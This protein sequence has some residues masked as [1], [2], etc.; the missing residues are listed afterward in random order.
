M[1]TDNNLSSRVSYVKKELKSA[2]T[3]LFFSIAILLLLS[4]WNSHNTIKVHQDYQSSLM[5][6][7]TQQVINEYQN[8]LIQ[9]RQEIDKFQWRNQ[10]ELMDL[11]RQGDLTER[12]DYLSLLKTFR[13][14]LDNV[15][16]FSII[17][18]Q[19][20]GVFKN[21][22]GDFLADCK[23]EI[24]ST[25]QNDGQEQLFL[26][27]S[28]SSVHYDL[29]QPLMGAQD[30]L[31]IFVA[32][33]PTVFKEILEKY[34]LP[35]Q[36]LFLLRQDRKVEIELNERGSSQFSDEQLSETQ[37]TEFSYLKEIPK[38][39][40]NVA[41]RL[42][43][44]YASNLVWNNYLWSLLIWFTFSTLLLFSYFSQKQKSFGQLKA[45][46]QLE[47]SKSHD[48]LTGLMTRQV[49]VDYFERVKSSIKSEQG[50]AFV[51]DLDKFQLFNNSVGFTK[52][53][54][55]LR[56]IADFIKNIIPDEAKFS[57][58][59]NDQFAILY[60][61]LAHRDALDYANVLRSSVETLDI[62]DIAKNFSLTSCIAVVQL[63]D[64]IAD[65]EHLMS[66][67]L[68][69]IKSAK[70]K[71]RN[72][73]L[74]YQSDDP[75]LVQHASEM[76]IYRQVQKALKG[77]GFEL[78]RQEIR[79]NKDTVSNKVYEVLIRLKG[80]DG[81]IISPAIFI[82]IAEQ[83]SIANELD[84][85]VIEKTLIN[86]AVSQS[87]D[88]YCINLSGQTLADVGMIDFVK[89]KV[90]QYGV[91]PELVT[92]EITET[93]AITHLESA[94]GFINEITQLGCR[95]A[96]DDFGSGLSSFSYLQKLPVQKLKI[97]GVFIK[98]I[99]ENPR[100]QAFV[101]TMVT[102]AKSM[103]METVAEFVE[104]LEESKMLVELGLDYCQGYYFHKPE[105][106]D[107]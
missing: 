92:F 81:N 24:Y 32:F 74:L 47:F 58:I 13:N 97:D 12:D 17:D 56:M 67:L 55:T 77:R 2:K 83:N 85:W 106:W 1:V 86:I 78:Y 7:V 69:T 26:H 102:L 21:I 71:G 75:E 61:T 10:A 15:R 31:Y 96:L 79:R 68:L 34:R 66:S 98:N 104:T 100:N 107:N 19:G 80:A 51:I 4:L 49:F 60:P 38:T 27:R 105:P 30:L 20:Q 11:Y 65:G 6:S 57:R 87:K 63:N 53:D 59:S 88:H 89:Q 46:R 95:F 14:E 40:W 39:R 93:F 9:L 16:L 62:S 5:D 42:S 72:Q 28:G 41:I 3:Q 22:T 99:T 52:G 91:A 44:D 36:E 18:Q 43:D 82:P 90:N 94:I 37:L 8:H 103:D 35:Q 29:L 25:I 48:N 101:S 23:E 50:V 64:D 84:K 73:V 70:S 54:S 45:I 33:E 76:E